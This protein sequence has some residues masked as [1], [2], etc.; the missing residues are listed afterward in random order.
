MTGS[1][2]D[3]FDEVTAENRAVWRR[4]LEG[5]HATSPGVWLIVWKKGSGRP[6]VSPD[7]AVLDALC[8]GWIDT[9]REALDADRY[10][11]AYTPRRP[12]STWSRINKE[13]VARLTRDG[14][15]TAAGLA[16]IEIAK[17]NGSWSSLDAVESLE[18]P[19]DLAAALAADPV[20]REHFEAYPTSV[21]KLALGRLAGAKRPETRSRRIAEIVEAASVVRR[22]SE[23]D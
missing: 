7:E 15:M 22:R 17:A 12:K 5:H 18:V 4:W 11:Q 16:A 8:F 1:V 2:F 10:R 13:R 21:K 23:P 6:S 20:A 19:D 14:E 9:K 3:S